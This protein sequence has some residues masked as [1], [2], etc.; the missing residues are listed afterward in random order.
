M[1]LQSNWLFFLIALLPLV[2]LY[3]LSTTAQTKPSPAKAAASEI[4]EEIVVIGVRESLGAASEL[5]RNQIE[6][7][8]AIVAADIQQLPDFSV[9]EALQ[10]VTGI[11]ITRDRGNGNNVAI[12]GLTQMVTTLNGRE[13]FSANDA[14]GFGRTLAFVAVP[15]E[16]VSGIKVYKTSSADHIEG[17]VAGSIDLRTYRPFDFKDY[18]LVGSVRRVEGEL[19]DK[20]ELQYSALLSGRL[21]TAGGHEW[22]GLLSVSQQ[23]RAYREDKK[24]TGTPLPRTD[25]IAGETVL[26]P[27]STTEFTNYGEQERNGANLLLQWRPSSALELYAEAGYIEFK[28]IEDTQQISVAVNQTTA[29]TDG[30]QALFPGTND[31][32]KITWNDANISVLSFIRDTVDRSKQAA[33]GGIWE[34]DWREGTLTLKGDISY[35]E[36]TNN[37]LFFGPFLSAN[38][39]QFSHDL[40]PSV[41]GTSVSGTDLLDPANFQF[42]NL[43]FIKRPFEGDQSSQQFDAEYT[44]AN[45]FFTSLSSGLRFSQREADNNPGLIID[46]GSGIA[47]TSAAATPGLVG[48]YPFNDYFPGSHAPSLDAFTV[49]DLSSA[50]HTA[51]YRS[52]FGLTTPIPSRGDPLG[53]WDIDEKTRA[54]YVMGNFKSTRYP[55]DGNIGLRVIHTEISTSGNRSIPDSGNTTPIG[56]DNSYTDYLPSMNLRYDLGD[57]LYGRAAASKTLTRQNFSDLTPSLTLFQFVTTPSLNTGSSGNP[58]LDPVRSDNLDLSLEKYFGQTNSIY[59][60]GFLKKVDGFVTNISNPEVYDGVTYQ[61]N[62]P[63][64]N[65][66]ADIKGIEFGYLQFYDFLPGYWGGL[67]LQLTYTYVDSEDTSLVAGRKLPLQDLSE[68]SYNI[69]GLYERGNFTARIAYNWRDDYLSGITNVIGVGS[70]P[71]YTEDY[72]WLDASFSFN[73]SDTLS[74]SIDGANLLNTIRHSYY[75]KQTRPS[76]S[77]INDRQLAIKLT[78]KF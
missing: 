76:R 56:I 68:H 46:L 51:A 26:V 61:V 5:K 62:R 71:I 72:G 53:L 48:V 63:Q 32:Q 64:N 8:D 9:T 10:R 4:I 52:A 25:I 50:R 3:S 78:A 30:S 41:P 20:G 45:G 38:A 77:E 54:L 44:F 27:S 2:S 22:G 74:V 39:A 6:I 11:Q 31:L 69:I 34:R 35:T 73:F 18:K 7:V 15:S 57:G 28:V 67:G 17:G 42:T 23:K 37:L 49:A 24:E 66:T 14:E 59:I 1:N 58:E 13:I 75:G 60:T 47:G 55:I 21:E 65:E 43:V 12:R 36:S 70:I 16:L 33:V 19:I 29:F 40:S